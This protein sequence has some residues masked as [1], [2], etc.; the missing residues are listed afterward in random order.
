[1]HKQGT[2][3]S[4]TL[5]PEPNIYRWAGEA[6]RTD[7]EARVACIQVTQGCP[8]VLELLEYAVVAIIRIYSNKYV[9]ISCISVGST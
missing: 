9:G 5:D 7:I 8:I 6:A 1:M 2:W 3:E 4:L